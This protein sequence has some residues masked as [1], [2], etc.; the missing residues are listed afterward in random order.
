MFGVALMA[1]Y[2]VCGRLSFDFLVLLLLLLLVVKITTARVQNGNNKTKK[3]KYRQNAKKNET[4]LGIPRYMAVVAE[5]KHT[6]E[7]QSSYRL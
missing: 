5:G 1:V 4:I 3:P 7:C 2:F 6:N